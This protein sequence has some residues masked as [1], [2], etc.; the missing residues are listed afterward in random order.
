MHA[1]VVLATVDRP[2]GGARRPPPRLPTSGGFLAGSVAAAVAPALA[3]TMPTSTVAVAGI[4]LAVVGAGA[5]GSLST[6]TATITTAAVDWA[7]YD[8]FALHRFGELHFAG[9]DL[10]ALACVL[11]AGVTVWAAATVLRLV[12]APS[13]SGPRVRPGS[14]VPGAPIHSAQGGRPRRFI[15]EHRRLPVHDLGHRLRRAR[16]AVHPRSAASSRC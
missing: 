9:L 4:P 5:I 3:R 2:P 7:G 14:C 15:H 6:P 16:R 8:G 11:G 12:G 10:R 1:D 13:R